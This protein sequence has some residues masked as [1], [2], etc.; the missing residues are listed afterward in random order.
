MNCRKLNYH[1]QKKDE[2][3]YKYFKPIHK[4]DT[5]LPA[6]FILEN[7]I[8]ILDQGDIGSCVSNAFSLCI[9]ILSTKHVRIS[10]L[11]HYYCGRAI[12][13][14]SS[15][16][17]S[18]LDIRMAAN[19]IRK[20]GACTE[21][22][23][24]YITANYTKLPPLSVFKASKLFKK[25]NYT[26]VN[27]ELS[28]LKSCLSFSKSPIIFGINVY[29]SFLSST[30][31]IVPMPNTTTETLQGGHCMLLVGYNDATQTFTC[32]NSWG[33]SWGNNGLCYMPYA[34]IL[35]STLSSD[36]CQLNFVL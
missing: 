33:N 31:G 6:Q 19:I 27:Q 13:G 12:E 34:Y 10:R 24:P 25:Y 1:F 2:R 22:S 30:N 7:K 15:T 20:F 4:V 17:D 5:K 35:N 29:D 8:A 23:W 21:Q 36:Y 11:F 16:L 3:D 28:S 14:T 32:A 9:S 18:G 26:F